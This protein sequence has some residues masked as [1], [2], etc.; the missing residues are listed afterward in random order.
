M[1]ESVW[2]SCGGAT[3]AIH[4]QYHDTDWLPAK[5]VHQTRYGMPATARQIAAGEGSQPAG[6]CAH[7]APR[8]KP[9]KL[10]C[11][12]E[13]LRPMPTSASRVAANEFHD[14]PEEALRGRHSLPRRS[15]VM[16]GDVIMPLQFTILRWSTPLFKEVRA[17]IDKTRRSTLLSIPEIAQQAATQWRATAIGDDFKFEQVPYSFAPK[18]TCLA[19]FKRKWGSVAVDVQMVVESVSQET[20]TCKARCIAPDYE[21]VEYEFGVHGAGSQWEH[22]LS[23]DAPGPALPAHLAVENPVVEHPDD[24][25]PAVTQ[26][27]RLREKAM[28]LH[29]GWAA[30]QLA[31]VH[32]RLR[33]ME[34]PSEDDYRR[35]LAAHEA[36]VA[37]HHELLPLH[38]I[39]V[40]IDIVTS[41][42]NGV[43]EA[44]RV[45]F[46]RQRAAQVADAAAQQVVVEAEAY[47]AAARHPPRGKGT[48]GARKRHVPP[49]QPPLGKR[50]K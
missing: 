8:K 25:L 17:A 47:I 35:D 34:D 22:V 1:S 50:Q 16:P 4:T 7:R 33:Q 6:V 14:S 24:A 40:A 18:E 28:R 48:A 31:E 26:L 42:H 21:P 20:R 29:E 37:A 13:A 43:R 15:V 19:N 27:E 38:D 23:T 49:S 44:R 2:H 30:Q 41:R 39:A 9:K 10:P 45:L 32:A 11:A 3:G 46:E 36:S 5:G 12:S